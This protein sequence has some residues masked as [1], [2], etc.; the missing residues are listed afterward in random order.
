[1]TGK[2]L[3]ATGVMSRAEIFINGKWQASAGADAITVINPATEEPLAT[4]PA[5]VDGRR[6]PGGLGGG[7][8]A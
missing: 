7:R 5:G 4:I 8:G 3:P 6:G 2:L 1:M